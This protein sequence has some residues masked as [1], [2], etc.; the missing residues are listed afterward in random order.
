[1]PRSKLS[2]PF[3]QACKLSEEQKRKLIEC[4]AKRIYIEEWEITALHDLCINNGSIDKGLAVLYEYAG[5]VDD[6]KKVV[7]NRSISMENV[8]DF[9]SCLNTEHGHENVVELKATAE[10]ASLLTIKSIHILSKWRRLQCCPRP[11]YVEEKSGG[12]W[13]FQFLL[14]DEA[15]RFSD[16]LF[17]MLAHVNLFD[18]VPIVHLVV[19]LAP[20][21]EYQ[22]F[23]DLIKYQQKYARGLRDASKERTVPVI[24][25]GVLS[26]AENPVRRLYTSIRDVLAIEDRIAGSWDAFRSLQ[27][28]Q[29]QQQS[30]QSQQSNSGSPSS[31]G[32]RYSP[33]LSRL[34][35]I[36]RL[37]YRNF[38]A[39]TEDLAWF[40]P[41]VPH[42]LDLDAIIGNTHTEL[43]A[44]LYP[45]EVTAP[46]PAPVDAS[47]RSPPAPS[48]RDTPATATAAGDNDSLSPSR[49]AGAALAFARSKNGILKNSPHP[50]SSRKVISKPSTAVAE[51]STLDS[52]P[53]DPAFVGGADS[54]HPPIGTV[55]LNVLPAVEK[56]RLNI[57]DISNSNNN[58]RHSMG[59]SDN[60]GGNNNNIEE[61]EA[62]KHAPSSYRHP[63]AAPMP[64]GPERKRS[65]T[66][67][68]VPTAGP[69]SAGP[70]L[71]EAL[72]MRRR[73]THAGTMS[74]ASSSTAVPA[75]NAFSANH[76]VI[77]DDNEEEEE[78]S[79][80]IINEQGKGEE[81][82]GRAKE[83][84]E[85]VDNKDLI[86]AKS[87][88]LRI[89]TK[90]VDAASHSASP[91]SPIPVASSHVPPPLS[92]DGANVER[93]EEN[94]PGLFLLNPVSLRVSTD[95]SSYPLIIPIE[96]A[97]DIATNPDIAAM[98]PAFQ[99]AAQSRRNSTNSPV[100]T[101]NSPTNS[102]S[103]TTTSQSAAATKRHASP[104]ATAAATSPK[105]PSQIMRAAS[106]GRYKTLSF[107]SVL[108]EGEMTS[109][110]GAHGRPRNISYEIIYQESPE[111]RLQQQS[112]QAYFIHQQEQQYRSRAI[113][114]ATPSPLLSRKR[115]QSTPVHLSVFQQSLGTPLATPSSPPVR[116][117]PSFDALF[118]PLTHASSTGASNSSSDMLH[119]NPE[120]PVRKVYRG[121]DS[122]P[123]VRSLNSARRNFS[124]R[125]RES[126]E[127]APHFMETFGMLDTLSKPFTRGESLAESQL[128]HIALRNMK[129][130]QSTLIEMAAR[131][132]SVWWRLV[133]PR[134]K[135][136][137]RMNLRDDCKDI[138]FSLVE[139][140]VIIGIG[141]QRRRRMLLRN[142]AAM[143][144]Q[145][146]FRFWSTTILVATR[147]K[148]L[149]Q[150]SSAAWERLSLW[151]NAVMMALKI[152]RFIRHWQ[153]RRMSKKVLR[154]NAAHVLRRTMEKYFQMRTLRR[155]YEEQ[156]QHYTKLK[157]ANMLSANHV[158]SSTLHRERELAVACIQ[159]CFRAFMLRRKVVQKQ[160]ADIMGTKL[161]YFFIRC[162]ARRRLK[163]KRKR[164]AAAIVIQTFVRGIRTRNKILKIVRSG[165][166]LNS[167]WRKHKEY[168]N[169]KSQ[170][171]RVDR[172]HTLVIHGIRNIAK[173]T[174]NSEQIKFKVSVWWHPLLHIVS[175][176]DVNV[177]LQTKQP[178]Y[179]YNSAAFYLVDTAVQTQ[180]RR[181]SFAQGFRK[182]GSMMVNPYIQRGQGTLG[183][184][185][186]AQE[187]QQPMQH[188]A[189]RGVF[190]YSQVLVAGSTTFSSTARASIAAV[191]GGNHSI[192]NSQIPLPAITERRQSNAHSMTEPPSGGPSAGAGAG[193]GAGAN[194]NT[195]SFSL[196]SGKRSSFNRKESV[197]AM[198]PSALAAQ[199][200]II[201]SDDEEEE[202]EEEEYGEQLGVGPTLKSSSS[203]GDGRKLPT[204]S[205]IS[206][207]MGVPNNGAPAPAP[208]PVVDV[209]AKSES[210]SSGGGS[211]SDRSL[212]PVNEG[213]F[214]SGDP[215]P[216][217]KSGK[218][219][220]RVSSV[221]KGVTPS[222]QQ[223][224]YLSRQN[225]QSSD[226]VLDTSAAA[227]G[228]DGP[229]SYEAGGSEFSSSS[230]SPKS[231]QS[232]NSIAKAAAGMASPTSSLLLRS[233][234]NFMAPLRGKTRTEAAP[235]VVEEPKMICN[236]HDVVVRIP[237]CHGNS[238]VK[239]EIFEGE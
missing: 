155:K 134:K 38:K 193:T 57:G 4:Q 224:Q 36:L 109:P 198:R 20:F 88:G 24:D 180:N 228:Q 238:V 86:H 102:S 82:D 93:L 131:K 150:R 97:A 217:R 174:I 10:K 168:V 235:P 81:A 14:K 188:L 114:Q 111:D 202:E 69:S 87:V 80:E 201:H 239:I 138:V 223:H 115:A 126:A 220:A 215:S 54:N 29:Q 146:M 170:L 177:I 98:A 76:S 94:A 71:R 104:N 152:F 119:N 123:S 229:N 175:Q 158:I 225:S 181:M 58:N 179:I 204:R 137:R 182:L 91:N 236:F 157:V 231:T 41:T 132:I 60:S 147:R 167:L 164:H 206:K 195:P 45:S 154:L 99:S 103:T 5:Y 165:L 107:D 151:G 83:R 40:A 176:N 148:E 216:V 56:L 42:Y 92:E 101:V 19:L 12:K 143:R 161:T 149:M 118:S 166:L 62:E 207:R 227:V 95:G 183:G 153:Q 13:S 67:A 52:D 35:P 55:P 28:Q 53:A 117:S 8:I 233:T 189:S 44:A 124:A 59:D 222:Q 51:P 77:L 129:V 133:G 237:G 89:E 160:Y 219:W 48:P 230:I 108:E 159:K 190:R 70:G 79:E 23:L 136:L 105:K 214:G 210:A 63:A 43:L 234:L 162:I 172:P 2:L 232:Y 205:F 65:V 39:P 17:Q 32:S 15:K 184:S 96:I 22:S 85:S 90:T 9:V 208:A 212:S 192:R 178:Q 26:G 74:S 191:F 218:S 221:V 196:G 6:L 50:G 185:S 125:S 226:L 75:R 61:R 141:K 49:P 142:G 72:E 34:F 128:I 113:F 100:N 203:N 197:D 37:P 116:H 194:A 135:L 173:K 66:M 47:S 120:Y 122:S 25:V 140:A 171:R 199:L 163:V 64:A 139:S 31:N 209:P 78:D 156:Y 186:Q 130:G 213:V 33:D 127:H 211:D 7:E 46:A 21:M 84:E 27:Q 106:E 145:R 144:I 1:M 11:L 3:S 112:Q 110:H 16:V 73:V 200:D 187:P 68:A 30:Q 169:L 18:L 121:R